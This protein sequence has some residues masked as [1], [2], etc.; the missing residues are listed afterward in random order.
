MNDNNYSGASNLAKAGLSGALE[1]TYTSSGDFRSAKKPAS[2][3]FP[4]IPKNIR[5]VFLGKNQYEKRQ[6][7][8]FN[9]VNCLV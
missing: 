7:C 6:Q 8:E 2:R 9:F 3:C 1:K 4:Q 5:I